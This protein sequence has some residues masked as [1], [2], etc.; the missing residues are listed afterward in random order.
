[1][2]STYVFFMSCLLACAAS[3]SND[4]E[5]E[6]DDWCL[7]PRYKVPLHVD[8]ALDDAF[9]PYCD[10]DTVFKE[11]SL[12]ESAD[13]L[14][15]RSRTRSRDDEENIPYLRY[16]AVAYPLD[17][18]YDVVVGAS[19]S[20]SVELQAHPGKYTI[21]GWVDY[22]TGTKSRGVNFYT[23]DFNELLLR[24]KY[25]Y[26]GADKL[27]LGYR[28]ATEKTV[29]HNASSSA[30]VTARPAMGLYR[31]IATDSAKFTPSKVV[32]RYSSLL[33]AAIDG[34]T[35]KFNWWWDD[36]SYT[37]CPKD[38]LLASDFVF[39]QDSEETSVKVIVE[40]YDEG[41]TM[42]ARKEDVEIPLINGG[43]TTI[44]GNFFS[45]FDIDPNFGALGGHG[46]SIKTEWD[47]TFDIEI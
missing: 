18:R 14:N 10:I 24:N 15:T 8:V 39:S 32:V 2:K 30:S 43:V 36:I 41:G 29:Q 17:P 19:L 16:Y 34:R 40:I 1:M 35:G 26:T 21:I 12:A 3:C 31:L 7:D 6:D 4:K 47:A 23:D 44:R 38:S 13:S 42:R 33:P 25:N 27:K 20:N 45:I 9:G 22:E 37:S 11:K 5:T 28:G 46:I